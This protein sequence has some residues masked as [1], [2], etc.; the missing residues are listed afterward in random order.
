MFQHGNGRL[1]PQR[2]VAVFGADLVFGDLAFQVLADGGERAVQE[3]LLYVHQHD[4]M[5]ALGE[6]VG[7]TVAHGAGADHTY[8]LNFH[9]CLPG[10]GKNGEV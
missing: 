7:D 4:V 2:R 9:D 8:S 1:A 10:D 5:P 6:N 3:A